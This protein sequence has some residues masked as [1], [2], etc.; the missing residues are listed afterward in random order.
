MIKDFKNHFFLLLGLVLED[1]HHKIQ[2]AIFFVGPIEFRQCEKNLEEFRKNEKELV[3]EIEN[4]LF[5]P[6]FPPG[7]I[8]LFFTNAKRFTL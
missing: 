4:R 7:G 6:C 5:P 2:C 3:D 1:F 8:P